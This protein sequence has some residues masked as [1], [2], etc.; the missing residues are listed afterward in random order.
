MGERYDVVV[1]LA[2]GVFPLVALAEGKNARAL[3]LVRTGSGRVPAAGVR[4]R[5]LDG[6]V[7]GY[8]DLTPT[9]EA[10]LPDRQPDRTIRLELTGGMQR[11][12]WAINGKPY[13]PRTIAAIRAGERVRIDYVNTTDMWH[14]MHLHGHTFAV[15]STGLRK[16]TAIV[17]PR[18][19]LSTVFDADNPG[20]WMIH[21]HNIYHAEAG[22]MTLL[23]YER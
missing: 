7:V 10:R 20:I 11:Y 3:G 13:D 18:Q 8:G 5:E 21:C 12:D 23:G 2:D 9:D 4:P 6:R 15:G 22:M 1:T 19:T 16:D 14:P 17:R